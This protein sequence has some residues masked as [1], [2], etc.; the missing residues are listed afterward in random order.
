[1]EKCPSEFKSILV[2]IDA[3]INVQVEDDRG[4]FKQA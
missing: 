2:F 3:W 4:L 1:M